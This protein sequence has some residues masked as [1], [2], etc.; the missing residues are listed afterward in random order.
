MECPAIFG[1]YINNPK[2]NQFPPPSGL[3]KTQEKYYELSTTPRDQ[4][5]VIIAPASQDPFVRFWLFQLFC[6]KTTFISDGAK[7]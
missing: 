4:D 2:A 5:E 7:G 6:I 1:S 3:G